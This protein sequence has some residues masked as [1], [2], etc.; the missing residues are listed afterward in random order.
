VGKLDY[1]GNGAKPVL[2]FGGGYD[3]DKDVKALGTSDDIGKGIYVVDALSGKLVKHLTHADMD[4]SIPSDMS[5][6]DTN[7]D[8]ELDRGYVGDTGGRV[9]RVDLVGDSSSWFVTKLADLGRHYNNDIVDDRRFFHRPDF[10]QYRDSTKDYDAVIVASGN[11][12]NPLGLKT[13]NYVYMIK[14]AD[15]TSGKF[16]G[17][18]ITHYNA[19]TDVAQVDDVTDNCLQDSSC[20]TNPSL[21]YG[22]RM[23]LSTVGEKSLATPTT[24][25]KKIYVTSFLPPGSGD[26][27]S[28]DPD[29]GSGR[30]YALS[31]D[32]ARAVNDYTVDGNDELTTADRYVD[33]QSGGIP[34]E[35]VY[36]PFNKILKPDLTLENVGVSGRWDTYWYKEEN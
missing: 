19:D 7:G 10:V 15:I 24:L 9:W 34:A 20:T 29:E 12:S 14:D 30:L 18:T 1:D 8:G 33:L 6:V 27:G 2:V 5:V 23:K 17:T 21:T 11:R 32:D 13:E 35:V 26:D 22:W 16:S 4:D 31:L 25:A 36:V 3:L 28:C